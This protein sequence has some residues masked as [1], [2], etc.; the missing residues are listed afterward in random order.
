MK[1]NYNLSGVGKRPQQTDGRKNKQMNKD[2]VM[3]FFI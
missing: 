1:P 3:L 2:K